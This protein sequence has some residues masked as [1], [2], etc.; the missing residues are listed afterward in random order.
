MPPGQ[1]VLQNYRRNKQVFE[2]D[3]KELAKNFY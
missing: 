2:N 3:Y 1:Y